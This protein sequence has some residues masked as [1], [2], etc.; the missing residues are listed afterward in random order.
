[1]IP[2]RR[3]G[4]TPRTPFPGEPD[5]DRRQQESVAGL[6]VG[7]PVPT[8][9]A[10]GCRRT[11]G[12][13]RPDDQR[14]E[15]NG[16]GLALETTAVGASVAVIRSARAPAKEH[17][18]NGLGHDPEIGPESLPGN[19]VEIVADLLLHIFQARVVLEIDLGVPVIPGRTR[20]RT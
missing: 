14:Q 3:W 6:G 1:M 20:C 18:G 12:R 10:A 19:V 16:A 4:W 13:K 7:P 5:H 15:G 17:D 11:G 2:R 9:R 8:S